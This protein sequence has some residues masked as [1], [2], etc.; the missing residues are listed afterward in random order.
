VSAIRAVAD[1][2]SLIALTQIGLMERLRPL[3]GDLGVTPTVVREIAG[4]CRPPSWC[5]VRFPSLSYD[6]ELVAA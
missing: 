6:G 2:S 5:S 3:F 1:A 4:T